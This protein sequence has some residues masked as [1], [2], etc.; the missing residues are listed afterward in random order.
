M[1]P[2]IFV[3]VGSVIGSIGALWYLIDTIR[4]NVKPNRVSFLLWSIAPLI[5]IYS[6]NPKR[7]GHPVTHDLQR[8]IFAVDDISSFIC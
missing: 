2:P 7:R 6:G 1:L 8:R 4:G 3:I 5:A